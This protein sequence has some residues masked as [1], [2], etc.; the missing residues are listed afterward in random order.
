MTN[1]LSF[2]LFWDLSR[3]HLAF[4]IP[5]WVLKAIFR[6]LPGFPKSCPDLPVPVVEPPGAPMPI[7]PCSF[8]ATCLGIFLIARL[9]LGATCWLA[10]GV[11]C[12]CWAWSI[13]LG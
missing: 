7:C 9:G 10:L 4:L 1:V 12:L 8:H 5:P 13:H 3:G 2:H 11:V 6:I